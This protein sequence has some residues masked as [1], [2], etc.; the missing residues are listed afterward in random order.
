MQSSTTCRRVGIWRVNNM[1]HVPQNEDFD[2]KDYYEQVVGDSH[3]RSLEKAV[4][5][6]CKEKGVALDIGAG[7]LRDSKFLLNEGFTVIAIDP[8]PRSLEYAHALNNPSLELINDMVGGYNFPNNVFTLVNAQG[9]LFHLPQP[10]FDDILQKIKI[11]LKS[12][13]VFCGDFLGVNDD[14]NN[15]ESKKTFLEKEQ[16]EKIFD[17]FDIKVLKET[18]NNSTYAA[19]VVNGTNDTKHWHWFKIIAVKK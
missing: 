6:F 7:N 14:W 3:S 5:T 16:I 10:R 4:T 19:S 12:G 1:E 9:I 2:W 13:G 15:S 8:S 11:S 18:E 17:G